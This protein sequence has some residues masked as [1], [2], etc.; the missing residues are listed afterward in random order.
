MRGRS[1]NFLISPRSPVLIST[2]SALRVFA[3]ALLTSASFSSNLLAEVHSWIA[4][5]YSKAHVVGPGKIL[6]VCSD[7]AAKQSVA[8]QFS[9]SGE[10]DFNIHR[11]EGTDGKQVVYDIEA[12]RARERAGKLVHDRAHE[13]CWMWSNKSTAEIRVNVELKR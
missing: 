8:W 5:S 12:P 6:E 11:H 13:W 4:A 7:I 2:R 10:L 1:T 9:S 3:L